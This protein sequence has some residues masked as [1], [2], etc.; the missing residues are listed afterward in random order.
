MSSLF[1]R[2]LIVEKRIMVLKISFSEAARVPHYAW[3]RNFA[4]GGGD[5]ETLFAVTVLHRGSSK[6][7]L[8]GSFAAAKMMCRGYIIDERP[9]VRNVDGWRGF[10]IVLINKNDVAD[11]WRT[12]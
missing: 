12:K 4:G 6:I 1:A 5:S 10:V 2:S 7:I 8:G 11:G 3:T 9:V